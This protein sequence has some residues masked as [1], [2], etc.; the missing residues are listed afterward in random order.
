MPMPQSQAHQAG[1]IAATVA[2]RPPRWEV[3]PVNHAFCEPL[4]G[5]GG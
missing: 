4:P 2:Q 5:K 3:A 1:E